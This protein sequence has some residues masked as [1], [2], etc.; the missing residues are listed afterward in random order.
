MVA[1]SDDPIKAGRDAL[2]RHAWREAY[3]TLSDA[4]HANLLSADGLRILAEA[5]WWSGEPDVVLDA[6]RPCRPMTTT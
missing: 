3:E 4:D 2:E 6:R 5:A 1:S